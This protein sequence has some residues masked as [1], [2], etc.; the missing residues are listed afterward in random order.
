[1][2]IQTISHFVREFLT[3]HHN[4]HIVLLMQQEP[5]GST[6][7]LIRHPVYQARVTYLQG[8][9]SSVSDMVR[10]GANFATALFLLTDAESNDVAQGGD[11][12]VLM[13]AL[14]SKQA[15]PGL[16]VF[17]QVSD[18]RSLDLAKSCGLDR[19]ICRDLLRS[20]ILARNCLVP[21]LIPLLF[22]LVHTY[23]HQTTSSYATSLGN[24]LRVILKR[25]ERS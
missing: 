12:T 4:G 14:V 2:E 8:S 24:F 18:I 7:K 1:M 21:G 13:H 5:Q 11:S 16:P 9:P 3:L 23:P 20:T 15:F 10:A 19:I 25:N 6:R 17:G 22:N